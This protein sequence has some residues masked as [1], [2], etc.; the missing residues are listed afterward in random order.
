MS[1]FHVYII[2]S[3]R[4]GRFYV[5]QTCLQP[6]ARLQQHN[7]GDFEEK[8]TVDGIPWELFFTIECSSREQAMKIERH[9]KSMK[10]KKYIHDLKNYPAI[11]QKLLEKYAGSAG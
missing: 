5:G 8:F 6:L 11:A 7:K 10:S 3:K 4:L 9:I 1:A 2:Y